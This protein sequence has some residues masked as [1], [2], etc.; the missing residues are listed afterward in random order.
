[1]VELLG[2]LGTTLVIIAYV[3]Q[4]KHLYVEKCAWGLSITTWVIWFV[5]AVLLLAYASIRR[6]ALFVV[7]QTVN[8]IAIV[9]TI[10][11]AKNS[12]NICPFHTAVVTGSV[13]DR[14]RNEYQDQKSLRTSER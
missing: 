5:A 13:R 2:W 8:A 11:L 12:T 7:V 10:I 1:M 6:D 4:I 14:S 9:V 3:P